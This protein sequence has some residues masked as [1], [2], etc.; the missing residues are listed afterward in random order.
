MIQ[1][2]TTVTRTYRFYSTYDLEVTITAQ[3]LVGI[4]GGV[5][6]VANTTYV[7]VARSF[8]LHRISIWTPPRQGNPAAGLGQFSGMSCAIEWNSLDNIPSKRF[9]DR[10]VSPSEA[11]YVSS[12]PP[13]GSAGYQWQDGPTGGNICTLL[14]P[15]GSIIDVHATHV[16]FMSGATGGAV[17]ANPV[18]VGAYYYP[19][20]DGSGTVRYLP[21][22]GLPTTY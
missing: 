22:D 10:S 14:A 21:A 13:V 18:V 12:K 15:V 11:S 8:R 19:P 9:A 3:A 5:G 6:T 20:L 2:P 4:A 1:P 17:T 7:Q 16:F